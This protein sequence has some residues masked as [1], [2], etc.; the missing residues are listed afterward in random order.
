VIMR[1]I[2]SG[3]LSRFKLPPEA[4]PSSVNLIGKGSAHLPH[5]IAHWRVELDTLG[6]MIQKVV[7]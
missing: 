2:E 5:D 7:S 1:V 4:K 6:G 3:S